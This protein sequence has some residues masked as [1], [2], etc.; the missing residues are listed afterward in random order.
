MRFRDPEKVVDEIAQVAGQWNVRTV[1]LQDD[2]L[3]LN[4]RWLHQFAG[5]YGERV[6]LPM[7]CLVRADQVDE[8]SSWH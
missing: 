8:E 6:G 7:L 1:Y 4:K 3:F 5:L 2:T